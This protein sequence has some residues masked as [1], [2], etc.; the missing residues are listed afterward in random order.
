MK[1][2]DQQRFYQMKWGVLHIKY[3]QY[4][5]KL[6]QILLLTTGGISDIMIIS[7]SRPR[8]PRLHRAHHV[9]ND[10]K[11]M[12]RFWDINLQACMCNKERISHLMF[13]FSC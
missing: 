5:Q 3:P 6:R 7:A 13:S 12:A 9:H 10:N 1:S 2:K 4:I 8:L 11:S